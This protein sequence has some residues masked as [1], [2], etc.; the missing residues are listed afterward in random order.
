MTWNLDEILSDGFNARP[1]KPANA[2]RFSAEVRDQLVDGYRRALSACG[3][4]RDSAMFPLLL[5]QLVDEHMDLRAP[6]SDEVIER[7]VGATLA[8]FG[9]RITRGHVTIRIVSDPGV[10]DAASRLDLHTEHLERVWRRFPEFALAI[11]PY[12]GA[13]KIRPLMRAF[14]A[15]ANGCKRYESISKDWHLAVGASANTIRS[16]VERLLGHIVDSGEH[17]EVLARVRELATKQGNE[18]DRFAFAQ[19]YATLAQKVHDRME[20]DRK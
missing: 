4:D 12:V 16:N 18:A 1:P 11:G 6:V 17:E 5:G 14:L 8:R 2:F 9:E 13:M 3:L 20:W 19:V 15:F 10:R 7:R